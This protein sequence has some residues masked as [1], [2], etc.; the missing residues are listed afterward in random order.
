MMSSWILLKMRNVSGKSCRENQNTYFVL[1]NVFPKIMP[2]WVNAEKCGRAGQATDGNIIGR[3]CFACW[4][5][6][7]TDTHSEYVILIAFPR[8]QWL[9]VRA[10]MLR[11]TYIA[12]LVYILFNP[13]STVELCHRT[14][15]LRQRI[16][17]IPKSLRDLRFSQRSFLTFKFSGMLRRVDW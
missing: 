9:H 2:L 6:K 15:H 16:I 17:W 3:M 1:N 11:S 10:S 14:D 13:S 12:S 7:A 4:I 8:Q 5:T